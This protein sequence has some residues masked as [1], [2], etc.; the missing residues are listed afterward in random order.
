MPFIYYSVSHVSS[1]LLRSA[2]PQPSG[3]KKLRYNTLC[4]PD[5]EFSSDM[6]SEELNIESDINLVTVGETASEESSNEMS[7]NESENE[8]SVV[9]C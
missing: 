9:A 2:D 4:D 5:E 1:T 8:T 3:L 7:E 6:L